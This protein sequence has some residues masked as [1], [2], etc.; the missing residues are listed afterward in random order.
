MIDTVF[1]AGKAPPKIK[2]PEMNSGSLV[3]MAPLTGN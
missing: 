2:L 3:F 1:S